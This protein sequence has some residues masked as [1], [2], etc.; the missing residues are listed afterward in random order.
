MT[1]TRS[2]A[3]APSEPDPT[4]GEA[5][6]T[7]LEVRA[8]VDT[9]ATPEHAST[10][11]SE[12]NQAI[13]NGWVALSRALGRLLQGDGEPIENATFPTF[14]AWA[15]W[16]L[17]RESVLGEATSKD[18]LHV[19]RRMY[20][21]MAT[22]VL[23]GDDIIA[24]NIVRGQAAI[25]EEAGAAFSALVE[26]AQENPELRQVPPD[27]RRFWKAYT[28]E[29][30]AIQASLNSKRHVSEALDAGAVT[31]LQRAMEPYFQVLVEGR[32]RPGLNREQRR[33][34]AELILLGNVRTVAYEQKRLQPVFE[35]NLAYVPDAI[36]DMVASRFG[37]RASLVKTLSKRLGE[38]HHLGEITNEALQITATR[39]L[40]SMI[41]GHEDLSF[42]RDV[43]PP[44]PG[45]PLLR[46]GQPGIDQRRYGSGSFF[47][48][49]LA[50]LQYRPTWAE[51]QLH[52]RSSGQGARTAVN[53]WLRYSE[54]MNFIVNV[55]RSRQQVA[56][57]YDT[58]GSPAAPPGSMQL[59]RPMTFADPAPDRPSNPRRAA[60]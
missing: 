33:Q 56:A 58:P 50:K 37:R 23:Q 8:V 46:S 11:P 49:A 35:R 10:K 7:L 19:A 26:L 51:W 12:A 34:R 39:R 20:R 2:S 22:A 41:V 3:S 48:T 14:A 28:D 60:S 15:A 13:L 53:N 45:N 30:L 44:P 40:F 25:Y 59:G 4:F 32:A 21:W 6:T 54:R 36:K 52:D 42:G 9:H 16:S 29:L 27:P 31:A 43:P 17:R 57:L 5:C 47:P 1:T 38:P 24:R 18:D 55:F